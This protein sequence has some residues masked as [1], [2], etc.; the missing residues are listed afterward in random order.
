MSQYTLEMFLAVCRFIRSINNLIEYHSQVKVPRNKSK[1]FK[2]V[3]NQSMK[4][5][6]WSSEGTCSSQGI[7]KT[8]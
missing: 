8:A 2:S 7:K 4:N 1:N 5:G 3:Q 6:T